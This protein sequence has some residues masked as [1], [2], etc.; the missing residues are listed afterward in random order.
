MQNDRVRQ[1]TLD[2]ETAESSRCSDAV[3]GDR[4]PDRLAAELLASGLAPLD[5]ELE[6]SKV[7]LSHRPATVDLIRMTQVTLEAC[8]DDAAR[9][10]AVWLFVS[11][12]AVSAETRELSEHFRQFV[13]D[14]TL[15]ACERTRIELQ[16]L[17]A[18][19][20]GLSDRHQNLHV[21][22]VTN[23]GHLWRPRRRA[24][25]QVDWT[26]W[27]QYQSRRRPRNPLLRI[28]CDVLTPRGPDRSAALV[29]FQVTKRSRLAVSLA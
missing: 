23:L 22:W 12:L 18:Y 28:L 1:S 20:K 14:E 2:R 21:A 8:R 27:I 24:L 17:A 15:P 11:R 26:A 19:A 9:S 13:R 16:V 3:D 25:D 29:T 4:E 10:R 5:L 6:L 7:Y